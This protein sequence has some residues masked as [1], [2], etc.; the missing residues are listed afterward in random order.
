VLRRSTVCYGV[1]S[2]N[3]PSCAEEGRLVGDMEFVWCC[4]EE[5]CTL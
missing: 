3:E 1:A 2:Q 5:L 4:M